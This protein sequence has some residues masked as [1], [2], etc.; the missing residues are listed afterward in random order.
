MSAEKIYPI[1]NNM[2]GKIRVGK[3]DYR[4][5]TEPS[6]PGYVNVLIH[7]SGD[8]SPYT[9][10]DSNGCIMENYWQFSKVFPK[11]TTQ[12]QPISTY[13]R[14]LIRWEHPAEVHVAAGGSLT[15]AYWAWRDKGFKHDKWVRYPA[16]YNHHKDAIGSVV[17]TPNGPNKYEIVDYLTARKL[18][19]IPKYKEIAVNTIQFKRLKQMLDSGINIQINEVDGPKYDSVYPYNETVNGSIEITPQILKELIENP[20]Q[21]CGHGYVLAGCLLGLL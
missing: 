1:I 15:L 10:K 2:T 12:R 18:L 19:Y 9:M 13:Q 21:A 16:G 3:Y 17:L 4:T 8:L 6:T 5:K 7:T 14:N 11:V 20:L